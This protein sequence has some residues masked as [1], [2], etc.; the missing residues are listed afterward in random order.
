ML[1]RQRKYFRASVSCF[2]SISWCRSQTIK[3]KIKIDRLVTN[4]LKLVRLHNG[5]LLFRSS[6]EVETINI[7]IIWRVFDALQLCG[8]RIF[9]FWKHSLLQRL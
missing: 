6:E 8:A 3:F 7:E 9:K 5:F 1:E 4:V 2:F